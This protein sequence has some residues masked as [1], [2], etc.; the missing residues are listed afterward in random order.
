MIGKKT[1]REKQILIFTSE[2]WFLCFYITLSYFVRKTRG[3]DVDDFRKK[4]VS[5][6]GKLHRFILKHHRRNGIGT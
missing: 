3:Y 6:P 4:N 1:S 5:F 2:T